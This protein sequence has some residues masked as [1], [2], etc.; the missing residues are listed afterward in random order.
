MKDQKESYLYSVVLIIALFLSGTG[1]A[2]AVY[3]TTSM[4][5]DQ[6]ESA[7]PAQNLSAMHYIA[8]VFDGFDLGTVSGQ[9]FD[10]NRSKHLV[11]KTL[12]IPNGTT[13]EQMTA[14]VKK[15]IRD[16][17]KDWQQP[18]NTQVVLALMY[19]WPCKK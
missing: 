14:V 17:P 16:N 11:Y 4:L 6:L 8:G 1:P 19:A 2:G 10:K 15:F 13:L 5:K 18:A 3:F 9:S 7:E 12:C